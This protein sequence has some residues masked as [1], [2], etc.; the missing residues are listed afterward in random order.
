MSVC[1]FGSSIKRYRR[2]GYVQSCFY[3]N[4]N[5]RERSNDVCRLSPGSFSKSSKYRILASMSGSVL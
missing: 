1:S 5:L 4:S 3:S 2:G